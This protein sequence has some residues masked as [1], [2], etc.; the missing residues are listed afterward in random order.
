MMTFLPL[1]TYE[2]SAKALDYRRL[3]KQRLEVQWL[4]KTIIEGKL[5]RHPLVTMW[6]SYLGSLIDYGVA[7]CEEWIY[8]RNY[9]DNILP[10]ILSYKDKLKGINYELPHWLGNDLLH[11]SHRGNL[12]RKD[13]NFYKTFGW[14]DSVML[15]YYWP[16]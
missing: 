2:D 4:I 8:A 9:S 10:K 6:S 14:Q 11:S 1:P 7:I 13:F 15:P 5:S 16:V 12:L 3:G